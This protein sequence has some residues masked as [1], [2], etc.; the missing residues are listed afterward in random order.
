MHYQS[1]STILYIAR[2]VVPPIESNV[3]TMPCSSI[4]AAA[5]VRVYVCPGAAAISRLPRL[6]VLLKGRGER[7]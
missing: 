7:L 4:I 1:R 6:R 2:S 3:A 5:L